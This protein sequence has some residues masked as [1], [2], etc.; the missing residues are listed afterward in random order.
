MSDHILLNKAA[1]VEPLPVCY[2]N[3]GQLCKRH[4]SRAG[5]GTVVAVDRLKWMQCAR[6]L[7][8]CPDQQC[9]H[10]QQVMCTRRAQLL[11]S[12]SFVGSL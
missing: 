5:E 11:P 10:T 7:S 9:N 3:A 6:I 2:P 4:A 12:R 8:T 1:D